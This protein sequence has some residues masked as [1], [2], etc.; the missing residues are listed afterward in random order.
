MPLAATK[1]VPFHQ[2]LI[3]DDDIQA[4]TDVL[5]S[6]WLTTGARA[7]QFESE[8]AKYVGAT[9]AVALGS[10]TAALHLALAAV[11]LKAGDEVIIPTM[12]FSSTGE[13]VCYF[14]ARPV[15]VDCE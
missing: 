7:K 1:F 10:C 15:L 9:N 13:V 2:A 5:R 12:T 4:V 8:F 3:E 14:D 11:G 6:R